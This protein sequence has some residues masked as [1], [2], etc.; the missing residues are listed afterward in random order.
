MKYRVFIK[1]RTRSMKTIAILSLIL[2]L[3]VSF[4]FVL[5]KNNTEPDSVNLITNWHLT[6]NKSQALKSNINL[7]SLK[8]KNT[9]QVSYNLHGLCLLGGSASAI[10]LEQDNIP[11]S[12]SLSQYGKNC[13]DGEQ[14]TSIPLEHFNGLD[15]NRKLEKITAKF[16]YP[17]YY[18]I[19]IKNAAALRAVDNVLGESVKPDYTKHRKTFPNITPI[20]EFPYAPQE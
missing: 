15:I 5:L 1:E 7:S 16:W 3:A 12:V 11:Y 20:R 4:L 19:D 9:L 2:I 17:T 18:S 13:F 14:T 10:I 6:G 8:G